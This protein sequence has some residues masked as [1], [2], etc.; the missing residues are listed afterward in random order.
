LRWVIATDQNLTIGDQ[1]ET[2][3]LF[4]CLDSYVKLPSAS[5]IKNHIM[6]RLD[7]V[8][9]KLFEHLPELAKVALTLDGWSASN[10]QSYLAIIAFFID[11]HWKLQE[12]VIGFEFMDMRHTGE[13]MTEVVKKVLEKHN[14]QDRI[15]A[16]TTDNASNNSSFFLKLLTNL[17]TVP[18]CVDVTSSGEVSNEQ[19]QDKIV[20]VPCLAHVLQ[21][22]LKAFLKS[23]RVKPT[24]DELQKN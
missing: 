9:G 23:V 11:R 2:I 7:E 22:A 14:I 15:L 3:R 21:L 12:I 6:K 19:D 24:N 10:R 18:E 4:Q 1:V 16:C 17:I 8:E 20:H 5:T 13:A